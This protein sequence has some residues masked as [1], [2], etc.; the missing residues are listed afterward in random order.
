VKNE[1]IASDISASFGTGAP[2]R[3]APAPWAA[4]A[5]TARSSVPIAIRSGIMKNGSNHRNSSAVIGT[6]MPQK[7]AAKR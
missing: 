5:T 1:A 4:T 2:S 3:S 7:T 6:F